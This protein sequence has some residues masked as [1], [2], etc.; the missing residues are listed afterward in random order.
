MG[1][2]YVAGKRPAVGKS[3]NWWEETAKAFCPKWHSRLGTKSEY[4]AFCGGL[5]KKQVERGWKVEEAWRAVCFD[6]MEL[7]HYWNSKNAKHDA[8]EETGSREICGFFDLTNTYKI[9]AYDE[10]ARGFWLA[11]GCCRDYSFSSP[12]ADLAHN[13]YRVNYRDYSVGWTVIPAA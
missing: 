7:G 5:I 8:F 4:V 11:S 1:I 6:S 12:L 13:N 3:F 9:L 10:E 2:C